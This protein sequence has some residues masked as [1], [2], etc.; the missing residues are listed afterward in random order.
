[1]TTK[2]LS[3]F[4]SSFIL[5]QSFNIH[6]NDIF[7]FDELVEHVK[8][9]EDKYGDDI[10]IFL[11][12]HYGELKEKHSKN[13]QKEDHKLPFDHN[14]SFDSLTVYVLHKLKFTIDES[15][16]IIYQTSN[17]FYQELHSS[18]EKPDIFQP[19]KHT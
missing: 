7:K 14:C 16:D 6:L 10:F 15:K 13:H 8:F 1:M 4:I 12:K 5:V 11:S 2:L 17:F 18:F 3:I 9:H 19:P